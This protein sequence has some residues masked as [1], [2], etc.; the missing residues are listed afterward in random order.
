V[1]ICEFD[2][3]GLGFCVVWVWIW[4]SGI[5]REFW[6]GGGLVLDFAGGIWRER[7]AGEITK[8]GI[9]LQ[10]FYFGAIGGS[11]VLL[12]FNL[13]LLELSNMLDSLFFFFFF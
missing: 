2:F 1:G 4:G 10:R 9:E 11:L 6:G 13:A 5:W 8:E 3:L 7:R 12:L